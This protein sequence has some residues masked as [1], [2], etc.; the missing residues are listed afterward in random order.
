[1]RPRHSANAKGVVGFDTS[2]YL[3]LMESYIGDPLWIEVARWYCVGCCRYWRI[4]SP[5]TV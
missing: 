2:A 5:H 3:W 1:M 4:V